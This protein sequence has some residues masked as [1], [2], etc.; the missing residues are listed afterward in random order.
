MHRVNNHKRGHVAGNTI[1]AP[2]FLQ[3]WTLDKVGN[4]TIWNENGANETRTHNNHHALT[5]RSTVP[6]PQ[7]HDANFNQ[8]DDG[9]SAFS[10][11]YDVMIN[12]S[13]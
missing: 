13:R 4:W 2:T 5:S 9:S 6:L 11:V 3:G 1:P 12:C 10:L 7:V 8:T